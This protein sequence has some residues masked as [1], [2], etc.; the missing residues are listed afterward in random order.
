LHAR[1]SASVH[2]HEHH[3]QRHQEGSA[4]SDKHLSYELISGPSGDGVDDYFAPDIN[5]F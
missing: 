2:P 4:W 3:L 1:V 5:L